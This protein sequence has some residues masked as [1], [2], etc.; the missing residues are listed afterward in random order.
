[1]TGKFDSIRHFTPEESFAAQEEVFHNETFTQALKTL[2]MGMTAEGLLRDRH[3]FGS[4]YIF[5]REFAGRFLQYYSDKTATHVH[6]SGLE[7]VTPDR[8]QLFIANHRDIIM[9]AA[10]VQLYFFNNNINTTKIA[11]GDNLVST[12]LLLNIAKM[13]KMFIVKRSSSL[14]EKILNSRELSEY[15]H[16]SMADEHESVWIAQRNGRTKDGID[17]TQQGL[18]KMLTYFDEGHDVL[19]TLHD[20]RITPVTISYEYEPCD[21]L[22][23]RELALSENQKYIKQPDEDFNSVCQGIFGF[24]GEVNL[25]IGKCIDEEFAQIPGDL[26]K[27]DKLTALGKIIDQQIYANYKL[28]A[29]NYIAYDYLEKCQKFADH[30]TEKQREDFLQYIDRQSITKDVDPTKMKSYLL[31]IYS[32]SVK[33]HYGL[34][35]SHTEENDW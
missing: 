34:E 30:Y 4:H 23:A 7:N 11:I 5:Q 10:Y 15:I 29:T 8:P 22:K 27:N 6:Y 26:R 16:V 17:H 13:N 32:N 3:T 19:E 12:P 35:L 24:K 31:Q 33:T 25:V 20:M 1:M 9:D 14:R 28:Y 21:S 2:N 18:L